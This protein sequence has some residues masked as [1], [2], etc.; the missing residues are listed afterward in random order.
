MLSRALPTSMPIGESLCTN[1]PANERP[2]A[3]KPLIQTRTKMPSTARVREDVGDPLTGAELGGGREQHADDHQQEARRETGREH[4]ARGLTALHALGLR[5]LLTGEE[6]AVARERQQHGREL[7]LP[8]EA[9][10][11]EHEGQQAADHDAAREPHVEVVELRGLV[12]R[13]ERRNQRV[14]GRLDGTVGDAEQQRADEQ[15]PKVPRED[16]EQDA[17]EVAD[18]RDAQ[19]ALEPERVDQRAA[20]HHGR[21]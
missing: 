4:R 14:A 21:A 19:D 10:L 9:Q 7:R 16:R 3:I 20:E 5:E 18:E 1:T 15:A 11:A 2:T 12:L 13:I 6:D 8:A 17:R